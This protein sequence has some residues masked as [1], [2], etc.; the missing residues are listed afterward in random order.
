MKKFLV[1]MIAVLTMSSAAH[2]G[3]FI[4]PFLGYA[5]SGKEDEGGSDDIKGMDLGARLGATFAMFSLGVEYAA[6]S[7]EED[8][9]GGNDFDTTD[10]GVTFAFDF[11]ILLRLYATYFADSEVKGDNLTVEGSGGYRVGIGYTGLPFVNI[12]VEMVK[13]I[14]DD[15]GD[16]EFT[17]TQLGLSVPLP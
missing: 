11:P 17:T 14:V 7:Y 1:T 2:A 12:N 10:I 9:S 5:I 6:G 4:E 16:Y 15:P 3:V 13:R 8:K